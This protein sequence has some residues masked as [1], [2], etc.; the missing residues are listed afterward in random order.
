MAKHVFGY[1]AIEELLR[2]SEKKLVRAEDMTA[3]E[4]RKTSLARLSRIVRTG[5]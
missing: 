4:R 5:A 3:E 1:H 2:R